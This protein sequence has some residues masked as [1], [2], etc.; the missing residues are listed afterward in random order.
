LLLLVKN[1]LEGKVLTF[2]IY[3]GVKKND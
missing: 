2:F 3:A 1:A